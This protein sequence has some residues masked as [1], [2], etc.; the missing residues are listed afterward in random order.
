MRAV[1]D[2]LLA[3][4]VL[5]LLEA[6]HDVLDRL[7]GQ[8]QGLA[9]AGGGPRRGVPAQRSQARALASGARMSPNLT[10]STTCSRGRS[11]SASRSSSS[12]WPIP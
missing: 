1:A 10:L 12:L 7:V 4:H 8:Q 6:G 2:A 9:C 11:R 3:Q 5:Q